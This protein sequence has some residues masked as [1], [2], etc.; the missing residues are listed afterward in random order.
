MSDFKTL[1]LTR[2]FNAPRAK[3][4]EALTKPELFAEW[5]APDMFTVPN[6]EI[7]ARAGGHLKLDMQDPNGMLY[8][9]AGTYKEVV[10]PERLSFVGTPLDAEGK[11]LFEMLQTYELSEADGQTTLTVT[12]ELVSEP[13][14]EAAPFLGGAEVG[15]NQSLDKLVKLVG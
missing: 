2:T 11:P 7:D 15:L 8:P 6:C 13:T 5:Y 12:S 3:V 4:W 1:N 9:L 14:P 10:E